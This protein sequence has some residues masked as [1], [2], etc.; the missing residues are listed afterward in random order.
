MWSG[1]LVV[2]AFGRGIGF[3]AYEIVAQDDNVVVL[4]NMLFGQRRDEIS[5][6]RTRIEQV[7]AWEMTSRRC[8][9]EVNQER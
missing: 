9:T 6:K 1:H 7:M 8:Y 2:G 3:S 5:I 4:I